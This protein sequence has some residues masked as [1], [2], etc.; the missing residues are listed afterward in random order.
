MA[1]ECYEFRIDVS[2]PFW[3][4]ICLYVPVCVYLYVTY[5]A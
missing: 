4:C 3:V 5:H 2:L 1:Y